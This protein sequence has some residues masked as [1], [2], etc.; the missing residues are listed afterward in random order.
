MARDLPPAPARDTPN[1]FSSCL[2]RVLPLRQPLEMGALV[3]SELLA[4]RGQ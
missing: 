2:G 1:L 3:V 4:Q